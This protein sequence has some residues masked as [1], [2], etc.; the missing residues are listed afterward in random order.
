MKRIEETRLGV[1]I[2][3]KEY[4]IKDGR[5]YL[6]CTQVSDLTPLNGMKADG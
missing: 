4:W 6:H 2:N 3:G 5:L 1:E